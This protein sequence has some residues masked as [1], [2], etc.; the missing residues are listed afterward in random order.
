MQINIQLE[1][2]K[3]ALN[4]VLSVIEKKVTRPIL[5]QCLI[6]IK[7]NQL[8]VK[9]TDLEVSAKYICEANANESTQF[10]INA[11]N[12]YEILKEVPNNEEINLTYNSNLNVIKLNFKNNSYSFFISP[13]E[14]FP[15]LNF[16][17]THNLFTIP[18]KVVQEILNK[19]THAISNDETKVYFNG[20]FLQTINNNFIAIATDGYRL[21]KLNY[22]NLIK[23][24]NSI[25]EDGIILPRKGINELKKLVDSNPY[26]D[27]NIS[28]DESF[29][30]INTDN[31]SLSIRLI[32]R[33]FPNYKAVIP[34][35]TLYELKIQKNELIEA[36]KRIKIMTSEKS[37][38][39]KLYLD[40]TTMLLLTNDSSLGEAV[41]KINIEY[42]GPNIETKFN[43]KYFL[44][45]LTVIDEESVL[46]QFNNETSPFIV[47]S[48]NK[49]EF[50]G[51]IMPM[52]L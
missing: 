34:T 41:E 45:M 17:N 12:I 40:K 33:E 16:E 1:Q 29:I 13:S 27:L 4:K 50:T 10:C 3:E 7:D 2:L 48:P 52:K 31:Y 51:I 35:K 18:G 24:K 49:K 28:L 19:A 20:I 39:V 5:S 44:E 8:I 6:E 47:C 26:S 15:L 9:G 46:I 14:D 30:Y 11:K 37:S 38:E 42:S 36:L 23:E 32:A 25:L 43:A 22:E 21:V